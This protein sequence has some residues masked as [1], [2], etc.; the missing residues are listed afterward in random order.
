MS[1]LSYNFDLNNNEIKNYY[2][3]SKNYDLL[4]IHKNIKSINY[5][6]SI[7]YFKE[8]NEIN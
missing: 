8:L 7:N 2:K 6:E 4:H 3:T 1:M 5:N